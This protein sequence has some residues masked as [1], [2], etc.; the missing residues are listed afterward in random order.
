MDPTMDLAVAVAAAAAAD[1]AVDVATAMAPG[2]GEEK[3]VEAVRV[4]GRKG[5]K[6]RATWTMTTKT[7][8]EPP[9][10][11]MT[12]ESAEID[13]MVRIHLKF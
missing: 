1:E 7:I 11:E 8:L 4:E 5:V 12:V 10:T 6:V 13:P 2:E 9:K 3:A